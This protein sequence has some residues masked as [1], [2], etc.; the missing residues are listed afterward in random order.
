VE[1]A[2]DQPVGGEDLVLRDFPQRVIPET[3]RK[4]EMGQIRKIVSRSKKAYAPA[5]MVGQVVHR[6][7]EIW[8]FPGD[9]EVDFQNWAEAEFRGLGLVDEKDQR[10]GLKRAREMLLRFQDSDLY[11]RMSE[12]S[13]LRHEVL[14]SVM[15]D[16]NP[17]K[18]GVIDALFKEGD[19]WFLVEFKT[20]EIRDQAGFNWI[21]EHEDYQSQVAGYLEATE[22]LLGQRPEPIL[23]FLG[24]QQKIHLITDR[25]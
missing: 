13:L 17:P 24:Y 12:S 16:R 11:Q 6:A 10:D 2:A 23:C 15:Q 1:P 9:G 8:K 21:W 20:D 19:S 7:L 18:I 25:W 3:V 22:R 14:F 4:P 5:W